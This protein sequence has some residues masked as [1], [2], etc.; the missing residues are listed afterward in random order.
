M[1]HLDWMVNV[2]YGPFREPLRDGLPGQGPSFLERPFVS[3]TCKV[4]VEPIA[5]VAISR[6]V[7]SQQG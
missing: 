2:S 6:C 7:R 3:N 5:E 1:Q 4:G